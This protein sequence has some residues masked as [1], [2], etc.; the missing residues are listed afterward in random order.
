MDSE[1]FL[2]NKNKNLKSNV[3][4]AA[5]A[6]AGAALDADELRKHAANDASCI[7]LRWVSIPL[8]VESYGAWD[9]E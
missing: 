5:G 3:L 8:V 7:E 2:A 1:T 9:K 6:T 4:S